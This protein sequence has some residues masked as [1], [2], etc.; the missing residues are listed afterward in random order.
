MWAVTT[1]CH[2]LLGLPLLQTQQRLYQSLP[3]RSQGRTGP[4]GTYQVGPP[5]RW[6]ATS[7][8]EGGSEA[9]EGAQGP[10]AG[11]RDGSPWINCLQGFEL[12]VTPLRVGLV[13]L[14][15]QGR[16][17]ERVHSALYDRRRSIFF[18]ININCYTD[19]LFSGIL[20]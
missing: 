13:C 9:E 6:A 10:L 16:L 15:S 1:R 5:A 4:P 14:I 18:S 2:S 11:G 7:N 12:Q 20:R 3:V 19:S 17:V 8:V